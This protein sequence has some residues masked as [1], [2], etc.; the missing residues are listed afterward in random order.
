[1]AAF[2]AFEVSMS[3]NF[4]RFLFVDL[5]KLLFLQN[6]TI[7]T[8]VLAGNLSFRKTCNSKTATMILIFSLFEPIGKHTKNIDYFIFEKS[9]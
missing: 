5:Y 4:Y 3:S 6:H 8:D 2:T 9:S 7:D 1:M